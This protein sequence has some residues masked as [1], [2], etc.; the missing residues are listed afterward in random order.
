VTGAG[1]TAGVLATA[2]L[3]WF[4]TGEL[5]LAIRA[6]TAL[7][8]AG[9]PALMI[10]QAQQLRELRP[11]PRRA[12]YISSMVSQWVLAALTLV[13][14][15]L[16]G[17]GM[18]DLGLRPLPVATFGLWIAGLTAGALM[19]ILIFHAAGFREAQIV[20]ELVPVSPAERALFAGV[21]ATAGFCEEVV[22]RGFLI[23]VLLLATGSLPLTLLLSSAVFGVVHAYQQPTGA[24]RA[25]LLGALLAGPLL[26][27]GSILPAIAAHALIDVIAGL[28]LAR[29]LL[30][31]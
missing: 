15:W 23:P 11:L 8:L 6:W 25:A 20:R 21:S 26:L 7:L 9:L 30:R 27:H 2:L 18:Q 31:E 3:V 16:G 17:M 13:I 14:A 24:L 5:P 4:N 28:W 29:Y 12:A 22:F 10:V 19:I 1:W